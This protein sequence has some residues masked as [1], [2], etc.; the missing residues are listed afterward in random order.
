MKF[1]SVDN[2]NKHKIIDRYIGKLLSAE[3][4]GQYRMLESSAAGGF[5]LEQ[6]T[7]LSNEELKNEI[8]SSMHPYILDA[9]KGQ[10]DNSNRTEII[11]DYV[12]K[13]VS[14]LSVECPRI[15]LW[16]YARQYLNKQKTSL[17]NSELEAEIVSIFP[18]LLTESNHD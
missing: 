16:N 14:D 12:L 15:N 6:K 17:S 13:I 11:S 18:E 4:Y 8:L 1:I 7:L 2:D 3:N 10:I 5:L 9:Y